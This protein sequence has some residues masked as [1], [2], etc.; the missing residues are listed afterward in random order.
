[1]PRGVT[2]NRHLLHDERVPSASAGWCRSSRF[3]AAT[4][5]AGFGGTVSERSRPDVR[6]G[7]GLAGCAWS[8]WAEVVCQARGPAYRPRYV[9]ERL[10]LSFSDM[11]TGTP[12][13]VTLSPNLTPEALTHVAVVCVEIYLGAM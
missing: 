10:L 7:A 3:P 9:P 4:A 13:L 12:G 5:V 8:A 2:A 6:H 1:M 11:Y